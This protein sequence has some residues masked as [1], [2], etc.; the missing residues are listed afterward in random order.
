MRGFVA[1]DVAA[2]DG[3]QDEVSWIQERGTKATAPRLEADA[4]TRRRADATEE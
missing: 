1:M 3:S 2:N 4:P